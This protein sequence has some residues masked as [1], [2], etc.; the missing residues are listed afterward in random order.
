MAQYPNWF[1]SGAQHNFEKWLAPLKGRDG[2]RF[3]QLGVFTGD[4]SAWMAENILTGKDCLLTDVDTWE[5]SNEEVH[6]TFDWADVLRN[7]IAKT[8]PYR[9]I[10]N[11]LGTSE[12]FFLRGGT[13]KFDFIYVDADHTADATYRDGFN[14]WNR[15]ADGGILAFDDY[16]WGDHLDDQSLAPKPGIDKFLTEFAGKY[17]ILDLDEQVW[18]EKTEGSK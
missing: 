11:F 6:H 18:I 16:K 3:L 1:A 14:S 8:I 4:A 12:Q 15:L 7:Y 10:Q 2:L 9:N 13:D 5:G 17:K